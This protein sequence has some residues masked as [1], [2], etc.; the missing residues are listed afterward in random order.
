[1]WHTNDDYVH[2]APTI[3]LS[4][5]PTAPW[6]AWEPSINLSHLPKLLLY[7][8]FLEDLLYDVTEDSKKIL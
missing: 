6:A 3:D 7:T 2:R 8:A 5:L 1:M 4:I